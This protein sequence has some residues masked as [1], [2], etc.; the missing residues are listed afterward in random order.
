[1]RG[2]R[3]NMRNLRSQIFST[4]LGQL[5]VGAG[6]YYIVAKLCL[7]LAL[8]TVNATSIWPPAGVALAGVLLLGYRIWP[9]IALGAFFAN[10]DTLTG[11]GFT[12]PLALA[13]AF[14]T[15]TGNTL[16]ALA[17]GFLVLHF[18]GG[19]NPFGRTGDI[20]KFVLFGALLGTTVS[21]LVGAGTLGILIGTWSNFALTFSTWW[22]G[23]AVG[24]LIMTPAIMTR[25]NRLKSGWT[26]LRIIEAAG[27]LAL[28]A[29]VGW[30]VFDE[31]LT[32]PYLFIPL[33]V[34]TALRFGQFEAACL[35][36]LILCFSIWG[37]LKGV[38]I[39][40]GVS[41]DVSLLLTQ[42]YTGVVSIMT[43]LITSLI[44]ERDT[45]LT[46]LRGVNEVLLEEIAERK[47]V[48]EARRAS[49]EKYRTI[50]EESFDGLFISSRAGKILD[51]NKKGVHMLG[52]QAKE[53]ILELDLVRDIYAYAPDRKRIQ[54]LVNAQGTGEFE[55]V[56]KKKSGEPMPAQFTL[57]AVK[58]AKGMI[59]TY[60]GIFRDISERKRAEEKEHLLSAIV[61]S[62]DDAIIAKDLDG[63]ILTWNRGAELLYGYREEEIVGRSIS[64]LVPQD[65]AEELSDL[66]DHVKAGKSIE[67]LETSRLRKDGSRCEVILTVSPILDDSGKVVGASTIAR[68]ISA[69]KQM[70]EK[71]RLASVYNRSLIEASLDP[72]ETIDTVGRITDVN[73][74]TEKVT[75]VPREELV[76]R[77]F[78]DFFTDPDKA[79]AG[80]LQ[81]FR[82]GAVYDY[83][84]EFKHRD[85]HVT[86]VLCNASVYRDETGRITGVLAAARDITERKQAETE[87]F[88]LNAELEQ[89]VVERTN[90]LE[91]KRREM[92]ESQK[93]LMNIVEDLNQKT[94][95]L[96]ITYH[97][98]EEETA[99]RLL[100]LEELREKERM[101]LQQSRLAALGE[102]INNVAHQWRQPLNEMGLIVQ[103]LPVMYE[104]GNFDG[105]YLRASVAKFMKVLMHTSKTIDDF[106]NFFKPD[107][108]KATFHVQEVVEKTISLI[109]LSFK[110]MQIAISVKASGDPVINGHPNEFSQVVLNI[111]FNARD[112]FL[113]RMDEKPRVIAIEMFNQGERAV[114]TIADN[115]GGIPE[116][117]LD[118]I[119]DPYF[120][121]R[122][123]DKGTGIGLYMSKIIIEKNIPGRLSVRN[124][125]EGAEFRIEA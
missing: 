102:M 48:E 68:D 9:A 31:G 104:K 35:I 32:L 33:I 91:A 78:S 98:L 110:Q 64:I 2:M 117:I 34:W 58:D 24:I 14:S 10:L 47:R 60:R 112:A 116:A 56:V 44:S 90:E 11:L 3:G 27:I 37:A 65:Q 92:V 94:A 101:L 119:F 45:A 43:M 113:A 62:S 66:L 57:T 89:R 100:A 20:V 82:E 54:A 12:T 125:A 84:L 49:E 115:A 36:L 25:G 6:V 96:E 16:Q 85:G 13:G 61:Q 79:K 81:A 111:L 103:E 88:R 124:T 87:I 97:E 39:Y 95:Q 83:A 17:S 76:G 55:V 50:F 118:K 69:R 7:L 75:G 41:P 114:V 63:V 19:R 52:Y 120:T 109:E 30:V 23:D 93:A 18:T 21:A 28:L 86:P 106:R 1:V 26:P 67:H 29:F 122:G 5:V 42:L 38:F 77:D 70:E 108:E 74:A 80:Y 71:L 107:K 8:H 73:R 72:L 4:R 59:T 15:A 40:H 46:E 51:I 99:Q 22:L 105:E 123:P 121:T 53:E